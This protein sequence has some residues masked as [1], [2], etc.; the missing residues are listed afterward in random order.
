MFVLRRIIFAV[1]IVF[2]D[3]VPIWGTLIFMGM[4][5]IMLG[6]A[7]SEYQWKEKVINHQHI[8]NECTLYLLS[9]LMLMFNSY[10]QPEMRYILGFILIT[11]VF[12][13]VIYNI[14][15]MLLFS[16]KLLILIVRKQYYK[17]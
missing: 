8:F 17:L 6:Y 14:I 15:I 10:V 7:L 1:A 13:F 2:M 5:L 16:C 11:V 4:T 9:V 12:I 3:Q